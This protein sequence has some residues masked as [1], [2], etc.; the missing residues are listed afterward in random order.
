MLETF[1]S[2]KVAKVKRFQP[3]GLCFLVLLSLQM[4]RIKQYSWKYAQSGTCATTHMLKPPVCLRTYMC[5]AQCL[6]T[7]K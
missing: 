3:F 5:P 6:Y 2:A 4:S 7:M 1:N